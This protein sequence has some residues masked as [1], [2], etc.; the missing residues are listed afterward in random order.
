MVDETAEV[1]GEMI[2]PRSVRCAVLFGSYARS[3]FW[4][5]APADYLSDIDLQFIVNRPP[6]FADSSWLPKILQ[7][8]CVRYAVRGVPGGV[9]K[10]TIVFDEQQADI[11][12][13]HFA[14]LVIVRS[15]FIAGLDGRFGFLKNSLRNF[16]DIM[17]YDHL[18]IKGEIAWAR[19]YQKAA[20]I[21]GRA[22]LTNAE[23]VRLVEL[24]I[25]DGKLALTKI[26]RGEYYAA[27][28]C[29]NGV[30]VNTGLQ[31]VNEIRERKGLHP[32]YRGRRVERR[33]CPGELDVL[34]MQICSSGSS[35][36]RLIEER[37]QGLN[38]LLLLL[39]EIED[40]CGSL[41]NRV[42]SA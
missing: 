14:K 24:A 3:V 4:K 23:A 36:G 16:A 17:R 18:I 37:L 15:L 1:L 20:T 31:L 19:F 10:I 33:L 39:F 26:G 11:V 9:D 34:S 12:L 42:G 40:S 5:E 30:I 21:G 7:R 41:P 32:V 29:L 22:R 38:D 8:R 6:S 27:L 13:L 2:R 25:V 35:L 28:R